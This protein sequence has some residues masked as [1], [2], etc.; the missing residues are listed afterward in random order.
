MGCILFMALLSTLQRAAGVLHSVEYLV[1][2]AISFESKSQLT[3]QISTKLSE[4]PTSN[5]AKVTI[6]THNL[7][8]GS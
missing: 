3:C 6:Q 4:Y 5:F 1:S 8:G 2:L 7:K